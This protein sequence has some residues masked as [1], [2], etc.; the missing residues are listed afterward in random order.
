MGDEK[1]WREGYGKQ[2]RYEDGGIITYKGSVPVPDPHG[3]AHWFDYPGSGRNGPG[4]K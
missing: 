4:K 1:R 3:S 2:R